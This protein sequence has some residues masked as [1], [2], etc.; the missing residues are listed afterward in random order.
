MFA[1][2]KI[3]LKIFA[4]LLLGFS[5]FVFFIFLVFLTFF[6]FVVFPLFFLFFLLFG[7][8]LEGK[9]LF[10]G[11]EIIPRLAIESHHHDIALVTPAA[12][13][14]HA[15]F[16]GV[17]CYGFASESKLGITVGVSALGEVDHL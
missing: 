7:F 15:V 17:I 5:F 9:F 10:C 12:L 1:V 2:G 13:A 6:I 11:A 3:E 4:I 16:A 14:F 8:L